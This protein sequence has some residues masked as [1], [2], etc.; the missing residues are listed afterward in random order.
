MV[1]LMSQIACPAPGHIQ[2]GYF[3]GMKEFITATGGQ[4][5]P[6]FQNY[7]ID[8]FSFEE[9]DYHVE[10]QTA[11]CILDDLSIAL[12]DDLFGL[13]LAERQGPDIFGSITALARSAPDMGSALSCFVE[14]L[15][16]VNS[17]EGSSE[18]LTSG[19]TSEFCW[20]SIADMNPQ[21]N[22]HGLILF[23]KVLTMLCGADF[24]PSYV[25]LCAEP[26]SH[27]RRAIESWVGCPMRRLNSNAIGFPTANLNRPLL[28]RNGLAYRMLRSGFDDLRAHFA[29]ALCARVDAFIS[30]ALPTGR[31]SIERC[32]SQLDMPLR[33]L[34]RRL[35]LECSSFAAILEKHRMKSAR[36]MLINTREPLARIA[37]E[38]GY[39]DQTSF[40]RAFRR[41]Y[42]MS[43]SAF[44]RTAMH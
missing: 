38:L 29:A 33:T 10:A 36:Q 34:Q 42:D 6:I 30:E 2:S 31:C 15:P 26:T 18:L 13:R 16:V 32:S 14:L 19:E 5:K 4:Y 3:R 22:Q 39:F 1:Q 21:A 17:P 7:D 44:R 41:W 24:K 11:A 35:A 27:Q 40:C 43:P 28:S 20:S 12:N 23:V 9:S 8:T 37:L 25:S